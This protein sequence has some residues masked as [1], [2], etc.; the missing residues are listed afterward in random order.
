MRAAVEL[1][2]LTADDVLVEALYGRVGDHD[3]LVSPTSVALTP[4][5][6]GV[7]VGDVPLDRTG[8]FGWTVRAL[9][10]HP[11]LPNKVALGLVAVP[12]EGEG[13][14]ELPQG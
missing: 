7:F 5:A 10:S 8:P 1:A 9:P 6:D 12:A 11:L 13:Y 14:T 4:G 3:E 2:G